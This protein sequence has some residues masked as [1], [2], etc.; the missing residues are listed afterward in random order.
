MSQRAPVA[1]A[2]VSAV[3]SAAAFV[4]CG[5]DLDAR[6]G[7]ARAYVFRPDEAPH[8][9]RA[10]ADLAD[11][12]AVCHDP[13][14]FHGASIDWFGTVTRVEP[15]RDT[16][17]GDGDAGWVYVRLA[18]R[19]HVEPHICLGAGVSSCRVTVAA[20]EGAPFVAR[21]QLRDEDWQ[22][23]LGLHRGSLVRVYGTVG[24]AECA[25]PN[26]PVIQ[27]A[28]YRQWPLGQFVVQGTVA[29]ADPATPVTH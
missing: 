20:D 23:P 24:H 7:H 19:H 3:A 16:A 25:G 12:A 4:G 26:G 18:F 15:A 9:R 13:D 11:P 5:A 29:P 8:A 21:L 2:V 17:Y 27:T 28:Y 10:D 6:F 1:V 22:G 14:R